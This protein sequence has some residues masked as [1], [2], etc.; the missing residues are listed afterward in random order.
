MRVSI[1]FIPLGDTC[2]EDTYLHLLCLLCLEVE[3]EDSW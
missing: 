1:S 2:L 3:V